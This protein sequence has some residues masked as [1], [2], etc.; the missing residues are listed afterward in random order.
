MLAARRAGIQLAES[1][2]DEPQRDGGERER[3]VRFEPI[4][5]AGE[6]QDVG[7]VLLAFTDMAHQGFPRGG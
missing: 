4:E 3:I 5:H 1:N 6:G 7:W 2:K